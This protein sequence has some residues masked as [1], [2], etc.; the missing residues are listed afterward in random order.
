MLGGKGSRSLPC[1]KIEA[2]IRALAKYDDEVI[3]TSSGHKDAGAASDDSSDD[4][5][6]F[7]ASFGCLRGALV[8]EGNHARGSS[9]AQ[10]P[11][12]KTAVRTGGGE[13][14]KARPGGFDPSKSRPSG[15]GR[16][17]EAPPPPGREQKSRGK[18][19]ELVADNALADDSTP[20]DANDELKA[21]KFQVLEDKLQEIIGTLCVPTLSKP[22]DQLADKAK[23]KV[24]YEAAS[25]A[26]LELLGKS[27]QA[28]HTLK[29]R[30]AVNEKA[31]SDIADFKKYVT[32]LQK[33]LVAI[34][35][36][37]GKVPLESVVEAIDS[38]KYATTFQLPVAVGFAVAQ[39][40]ALDK[41]K[42]N[43]WD[44]LAAFV[45]KMTVDSQNKIDAGDLE[46]HM[47]YTAELCLAKAAPRC[48]RSC[49]PPAELGEALHKLAVVFSGTPD[50]LSD[51]DAASFIQ[52]RDALAKVND[53]PQEDVVN[54]QKALEDLTEE[55]VPDDSV[56]FTLVQLNSFKELRRL[57]MKDI[58][59]RLEDL[60]QGQTLNNAGVELIAASCLSN[61]DIGRPSWIG[62]PT[63]H[64]F[65]PAQ[66]TIEQ[67]RV[68][69]DPLRKLSFGQLV[70]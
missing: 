44:D 61:S 12:R 56:L 40:I 17:A 30:K 60:T 39:S 19:I 43:R 52:L 38:T 35:T 53:A 62:P 14:P 24:L 25:K 33:L 42:Y 69:D 13:P 7:G 32:N 58:K 31:V 26:L 54:T 1:R 6:D 15:P 64:K 65:N 5:V 8:D 3:D 63:C 28:E 59:V 9:S 2:A 11:A 57:C 37:N 20:A 18:A 34:V 23:A 48:G 68:P 36:V 50:A 27:A 66:N 21:V 51:R 16:A 45:A 67:N 4:V 55:A 41:V 46:Q 70:C 10:A 22:C 47:R 49:R 29:R